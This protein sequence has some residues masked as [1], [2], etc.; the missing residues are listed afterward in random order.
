[1]VADLR[2]QASKVLENMKWLLVDVNEERNL[3]I[4]HTQQYITG[5]RSC[6]QL[7]PIFFCSVEVNRLIRGLVKRYTTNGQGN[8]CVVV[9][10]G[11]S[12]RTSTVK[13]V[14]EELDLNEELHVISVAQL[15]SDKNTLKVLTDEKEKK[16]CI[17]VIEDADELAARQRQSILYLLLDAV[18]NKS[19]CNWLVFLMVQHQNFITSLE[20]RVRS[21]L[22]TARIVFHSAANIDE[23]VTAFGKFLGKE[24]TDSSD[25]WLEFVESILAEP[26]I[27][28]ELNY[29]FSVC[30]AVCVKRNIFF[31]HSFYLYYAF[32][33]LK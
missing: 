13:A 14:I 23:Y 30:F 24:N 17:L 20:K 22:P 10:K 1:M 12:G 26:T 5:V 4:L 21:R 9:G 33:L 6:T 15:G 2:S 18:R 29:M 31:F 19:K 16:N 25:G 32:L 28:A 3:A 11:N 27:I 7:S 8:A